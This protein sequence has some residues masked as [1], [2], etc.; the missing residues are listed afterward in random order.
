[1]KSE[2]TNREQLIL[3]GLYLSKFDRKGLE[4]LGFESF[5]EAFNVLGYALE[6]K[7]MNIKNYRDEFDPYFENRRQGW[8]K[9][10]MRDYCKKIYDSAKDFSFDKFSKI[11]AGFLVKD[12]ELKTEIN[13]L[14]KQDADSKFVNRISTGLAAENF[15]IDNYSQHF[16][17][18]TL[19]DTRTFGCGFDFKLN[20]GSDFFCIEVKGLQTNSGN[21]LMTEKEF[22]TAGKLKE[23]Y[24]LYIVRNFKENPY[25]NLFFNPLEKF[26]LKQF[27]KQIIQV[28][29][30]GKI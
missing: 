9:R 22:D 5:T 28:N 4:K 10:E 19:Q 12:F 7:P 8:H 16:S 3:T 25:E 24:C 6:G 29:Y 17:N 18:F 14:L 27:S 23:K 21:F 2:V 13:H 30:Q 15:F 1:M 11:I 26:E 20:N